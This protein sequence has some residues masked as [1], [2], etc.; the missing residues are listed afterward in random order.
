MEN[1]HPLFNYTQADKL[2]RVKRPLKIVPKNIEKHGQNLGGSPWGRV[3]TK[4]TVARGIHW[5]S[6][7]SHGGWIISKGLARRLLPEWAR[8]RASDRMTGYL[9][10]EE[11]CLYS[12][13]EFCTLIK[14]P[15]LLDTYYARQNL[16]GV[17]HWQRLAD[18]WH[19]IDAT[20][21]RWTSHYSRQWL[22]RYN[23]DNQ[24]N[25]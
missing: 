5:I 1:T 9:A 19:A 8:A 17:P 23:V 4:Y 15:S 21:D 20:Q 24:I 10:Y 13:F 22:D 6:T 7:P 25:L 3:Q 18:L 11:D 2:K 16:G 14:V 12:V